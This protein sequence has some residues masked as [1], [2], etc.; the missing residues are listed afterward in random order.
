MG[1]QIGQVYKN[2]VLYVYDTAWRIGAKLELE[3][4]LVYLHAGTRKGAKALGLDSRR[5]NIDPQDL[6]LPLQRLRPIHIENFLCL[7]KDR[8]ERHSQDGVQPIRK[9]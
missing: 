8:L 7:Y 2:A 3:P 4:E 1:K 9:C 6:P 5:E